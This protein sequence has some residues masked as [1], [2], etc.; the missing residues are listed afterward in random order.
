MRTLTKRRLILLLLMAVFSAIVLLLAGC[1]GPTGSQGP[2]GPPGPAGRAGTEG[3]SGKAGTP[4]SAGSSGPAGPAGVQAVA[5]IRALHEANSPQYNG[6]CLSCHRDVMQRTTLNPKIQDVHIVMMPFVEG[7]N[8]A[9]G[10]T[11]ANCTSCHK[12]V[13]FEG[14]ST[15]GIRNEVDAESCAR[16]HGP[17]GPGKKFYAQ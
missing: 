17:A 14:H 6:D 10:P 8:A 3:S 1:Q 16:C 5:N 2:P 4:G 7:Y 13:D 12:G 9:K 11:N 15:A